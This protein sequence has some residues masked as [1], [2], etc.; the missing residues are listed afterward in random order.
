MY[1]LIGCKMVN[2]E[3]DRPVWLV[4]RVSMSEMSILGF[5][6]TGQ[7]DMKGLYM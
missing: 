3:R 1:I 2:V 7:T 5:L 4:E 6:E